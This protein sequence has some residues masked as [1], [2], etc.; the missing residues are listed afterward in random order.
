MHIL[1]N[2]GGSVARGIVDGRLGSRVRVSVTP[3]GF[4]GGWNVVWVRFSG[5]PPVSS[6]TNFLP[7]FLHTQLFHF[8]SFHFIRS[9]DG[10]SGVV[11]R[12]HC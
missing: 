8:V 11:S 6:T 9:C 3:C 1:K 2:C 7:P 5:V 4:R 10:E 12:H